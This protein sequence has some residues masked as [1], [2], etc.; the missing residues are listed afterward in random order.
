MFIIDQ[1]EEAAIYRVWRTRAGKRLRDMFHNIRV[2]DAS[3]HW[4]TDE[5]LKALRP[6]WDSPAFKE[7]QVKAQMSRGSARGGSLH[8][9]G[10]ITIESMQLKM[11]NIVLF[12]FSFSIFVLNVIYI[13]TWKFIEM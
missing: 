3:T 6:Y 12:L 10:F 5:I 13:I 9:G 11:V 1:R 7:K 4:L 8:I 2:K